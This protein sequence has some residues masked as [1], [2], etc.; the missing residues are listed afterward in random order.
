MDR[1]L[2]STSHGDPRPA[3]AAALA[4]AS[5]RGQAGHCLDYVPGIRP[6]PSTSSLATR[7]LTPS[8]R[9]EPDDLGVITKPTQGHGGHEYPAETFG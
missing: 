7:D 4:P 3:R 2:A 1:S 5:R 6:P 8:H 9:K